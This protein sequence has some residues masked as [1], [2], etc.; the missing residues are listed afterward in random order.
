[1]KEEIYKLIHTSI[2]SSRSLRTKI[3]DYFSKLNVVAEDI[4]IIRDI[5]HH[6]N[7]S[8]LFHV[9]K[10]NFLIKS[11]NTANAN[12]SSDFYLKWFS[13]LAFDVQNHP[14]SPSDF[15]QFKNLIKLWTE[16][17]THDYD[18]FIHMFKNFDQLSSIFIPTE[19]NSRLLHFIEKMIDL[20]FL[21]GKYK[22]N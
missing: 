12:H 20:A 14:A 15:A 22:L 1:M 8:L 6:S 10:Q 21:K 13:F 19:N 11:L 3:T 5:F 4:P 17:I 16:C 2:D 18:I 7:T 9:D